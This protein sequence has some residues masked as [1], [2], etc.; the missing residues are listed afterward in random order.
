MQLALVHGL[1]ISEQII[2]GILA[3]AMLHLGRSGW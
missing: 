2:F 3:L 1:N